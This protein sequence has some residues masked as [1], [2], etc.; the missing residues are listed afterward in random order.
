MDYVQTVNDQIKAAMVSGNK[1]RLETL[2]SIRA[3]IIEFEKSGS[4]KSLGEEDFVKIVSAAA[5]KRK[6]AIEQFRAN[7]RIEAAEKEEQELAIL[8]EFMPAQMN[9]SEVESEVRALAA[10]VGATSAADFGKLMGAVM[11]SLKG[12]A[13]GGMIQTVVKKVLNG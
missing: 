7:N 10:E 11:K 4:G 13:D 6:D 8:M 9:E 5:K 12:K 2:R 1:L 3:G